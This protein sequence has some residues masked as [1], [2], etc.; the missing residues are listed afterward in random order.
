MKKISVLSLAAS[1]VAAFMIPAPFAQGQAIP[2]VPAL[3][4]S[5]NVEVIGNVPGPLLG[6]NFSGDYAYGTGPS[7]LTIFD[8]SEPANPTVV[9]EL[10]IP[11][12][13]N[14]DVDICGDTLLITNDRETRD[15]GA[16]LYVLDISDPGAPALL[17]ETPVGWTGADGIRG[18]GHIANFVSD[19]CRWVWLDGGD[20]VDVIDLKDR[21]TPVHVGRFDSVASHSPA[22]KVSHDTEKDGRGILWNVGGGGA[23][24]YKLTKNP[25][26]PKLVAKTGPEA[27]NPSD[28][29]DFILHNSK[30]RGKTLLVTEEDYIDTDEAQPGSCNGQGKFETYALRN[31]PKAKAKN[32]AKRSRMGKVE[33]LDTWQTELNG[34][35]AGGAADSKAPVTVNCS[36]HWFDEQNGVAAV[37]WY[38]QGTRFLDVTNPK[39]IRQVGYYL[40][41]NGSTWA[42]YW[43]PTDPTGTI[44]YTADA[45]RG[46]DV[47]KIDNSG[48]GAETTTA[49]V[50]DSWFGSGLGIPA[51][52]P[53]SLKAHPVFGWACPILLGRL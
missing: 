4:T 20:Q 26:K 41:L 19:N 38:E 33:N 18:G 27:S 36:S 1:C 40:P 35:V 21:A 52:S 8:I 50:P 23:A 31:M 46:L 47:L 2:T 48:L 25:L 44:V 51:A 32:K 34:I 14:E 12:F 30:R 28:L 39:D 24:G 42:S 45:Y 53:L 37:G 49:P 15:I 22:F 11:H 43:S 10:P 7:G 9:G 17:S 6:L 3:A 29:N 5:E 16:V 13:E